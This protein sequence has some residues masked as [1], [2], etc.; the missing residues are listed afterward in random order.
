MSQGSTILPLHVP[1][2]AASR[3]SALAI[4]VAAQFMF[5][6]DAFIINV[7]LPSIRADLAATRGDMH[8]ILAL[9][10]IAFAVLVVAGGRLGD[11]QAA[12]SSSSW[13]WSASPAPR[14]G[15]GLREAG[16]NS[17]W[18]AQAKARPPR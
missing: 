9:Y 8:G 18:P 16:P 5:V 10:Q 7:A 4:L 1:G 2:G 15:V 13:A 14:S 6:V 17:C 12:R 11:I 3:W